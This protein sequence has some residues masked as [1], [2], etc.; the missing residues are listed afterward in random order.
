MAPPPV[1]I[2]IA[3]AQKSG[4]TSLLRY[5]EQH[6]QLSGQGPLEISFFFN[7]DEWN[8]GWEQCYPK[9]FYD[10]TTD[11][12]VAKSAMLYA[13][14]ICVERLAEHNP[15]CSVVLILRDPVERAWSSYR[16]EREKSWIEDPFEHLLTVLEDREDIWNRLFIQFGEYAP[17]IRQLYRFFPPDQLKVLLYDDF[18]SRPLEACREVFRFV[19]VD[20]SYVPE[21]GV[22]HNVHREVSS[23][24]AAAVVGWLRRPQNPVRR[25]AKQTLP[26]RVFNRLGSSA[27]E[28]IRGEAVEEQ[29]PGRVRVELGRY[30]REL[31]HELE[32]LLSRDL[33]HWSGVRD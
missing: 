1:S 6:P 20:D 30:Y 27:V 29:M 14:R 19:G 16:M 9:Y 3:G 11:Q 13:R 4:T 23:W 33:S 12:L 31:N 26:P 2:A 25:L 17:A 22:A 10:A 8:Q 24:A 28:A 15:G 18:V 5:L 32:S 7:E 21:T